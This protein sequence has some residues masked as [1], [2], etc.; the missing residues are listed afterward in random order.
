MSDFKPTKEQLDAIHGVKENKTIR[1]YAKA[2]TGKTST[3]V[4]IAKAYASSKILY[5]AFNTSIKNEAQEKFSKNT[6]IKTTHGL[7][8]YYIKKH[9]SIDL[10][11]LIGSY[12]PA[13]IS[14]LFSCTFKLAKQALIVLETFLNSTSPRIT[15]DSPHSSIAREIFEAMENSSIAPT[16]SFY[17]KKFQL[18]LLQREIEIVYDITMLDETQDTNPVTYSIFKLIKAKRKVYVGDEHQAIYSFRGAQNAMSMIKNA[19]DFFL[20]NTFRYNQEIAD[21]ANYLLSTYK[22][23]KH[24]IESQVK[25]QE[26]F[27]F[28]PQKHTICYI[29]RTNAPLV[30]KIEEL[31]KSK[32]EFVT[33]RDP[34]EI[35]NLVI[36]IRNLQNGDFHKVKR[37]R[38]LKDYISSRKVYDPDLEQ[39]ISEDYFNEEAVKE[40]ASEVEDKELENALKTASKLGDKVFTL[41]TIASKM[42]TKYKKTS[43]KPP[44]HLSTAHTSK[45]LEWDCIHIL[46]DFPS[47]DDILAEAKCSD[48]AHFVQNLD[49]TEPQIIEEINLKYVTITRAKQ[50]VYPGLEKFIKT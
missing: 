4:S 20:T 16:H 36:D 23:D 9:T 37:N 43:K 45:G 46:D 50:A 22:G 24:S 13:Q 19:K 26:D 5:L 33:A 30:E 41:E 15:S 12:K 39:E 28:D 34:Y 10:N 29:S 25:K 18:M 35:F 8:Y 6:S 7:A 2:G 44:Y 11:N 21:A 48:P 14:K 3:L 49:V 31:S 32:E 42:H 38:Y 1:I 40:Y 27:Q 17:L 47:N